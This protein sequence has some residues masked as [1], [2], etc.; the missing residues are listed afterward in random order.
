QLPFS[1]ED[2]ALM[3]KILNEPH[4]PL[5]DFCANCPDGLQDIVDR[6]LAKSVDDRY[7]TAEEM[8]A[9]LRSVIEEL[10]KEQVVQ[11]LPEA[12]RLVDAQ[13]YTRARIVLQ[14]VLKVQ[15]KH[16]GAR[17]LLSEIQRRIVQRQ[18]DERLRNARMQ[19]EDALSRREFDQGLQVLKEGLEVDPENADLLAL[20]ETVL[21]EKRK[22]EQVDALLRQVDNA[23]RKG[24]YKSA[25][26][27]AQEALNVDRSNSKVIALCNILASE[28]D[29]AQKKAQAKS[30]I[31]AVRR[32][33]D[34]RRFDQAL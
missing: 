21:Q 13:D 22:Q 28:A 8:A 24:D 16:T 23:R 6:S 18:R 26:A 9:D 34:G 4:P 12:R 1:G 3:Q 33:L 19:A 20:K 10:S 29:Q 14:Q 31:E 25:M 5:R 15:S 17:E 11:L 2:Y 7:Q 27:S 30:M 32:H